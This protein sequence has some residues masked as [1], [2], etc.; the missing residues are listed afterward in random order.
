[1]ST[2][3][4]E[5]GS[6]GGLTPDEDVSLKV[7]QQTIS[8]SGNFMVRR[9]MGAYY[10]GLCKDDG[11]GEDGRSHAPIDDLPLYDQE[12]IERR[13]YDLVNYYNTDCQAY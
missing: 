2:I 13:V 1:M 10:L 12:H 3:F 8:T 7:M 9:A 6:H 4:G 11:L 5:L